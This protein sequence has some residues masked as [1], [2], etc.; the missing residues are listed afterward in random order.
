MGRS[1]AGMEA[2]LIMPAWLI[3]LLSM[4]AWEAGSRGAAAL[5]RKLVGKGAAEV[6]EAAGR[7]LTQHGLG[8]AINRGAG[9]MGGVGKYLTAENLGR[10]AVGVGATMGALTAGSLAATGVEGL[11]HPDSPGVINMA[12]AQ[13]P[14]PAMLEANANVQRM[15]QM[16]ALRQAIADYVGDEHL[17]DD[18]IEELSVRRVV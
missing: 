16:G 4:G 8:Q 18:L 3:W 7:K 14:S 11:F 9:A 5:G 6:A 12:Q 2:L 15:Q 10:G 13:Q 1:I 17:A